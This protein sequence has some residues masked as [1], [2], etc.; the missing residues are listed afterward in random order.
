M[1][2]VISKGSR[3]FYYR[4]AI[5]VFLSFIVIPFVIRL[6][7]GGMDRY[8]D[9]NLYNLNLFIAT[10]FIVFIIIN[11]KA[12]SEFVYSQNINQTA[13]FFLGSLKPPLSNTP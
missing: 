6:F 8:P 4:L 5:F 3:H 13:L 11:K 10:A 1:L 7:S 12:I 9:L 2:S